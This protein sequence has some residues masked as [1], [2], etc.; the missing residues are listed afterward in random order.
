MSG[1]LG[2]VLLGFGGHSRSVADVALAAGYSRLLFV[3]ENARDGE[4]FL[5]FPVQSTMPLRAGDWVYMPCAGNNL[6]RLVQVRELQA[7]SLPLTSIVSPSA[8]VGRGAVVGP[9]CFIGHHAH[10]GPLTRLGAGCIINTGA[11]VEH[12][13]M[14][15]Q[16]T[17]VS[18]HS[19]IAGYCK[20]GDRSFL[21]AGSAVIDKVSIT[22]DVTVGAGGVVVSAIDSPGVYAGVPVRRISAENDLT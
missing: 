10:V 18:V 12:D 5:E 14:I 17:H 6:R 19:C 9:G 4:V 21:G 15:G 20:V 11:V 13:C 1:P 22:C 7:A 16:G 2:L 8:T 3:D